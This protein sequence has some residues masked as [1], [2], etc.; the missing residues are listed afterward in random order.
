MYCCDES[1]LKD[2][3][4]EKSI[5]I[6]FETESENDE[7]KQTTEK[8]TDF[9]Y[10]SKLWDW[11]KHNFLEWIDEWILWKDMDKPLGSKIWK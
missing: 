11:S 7:T 9:T 8:G 4:I 1:F 3:Q 5:V 6:D 10:L 2:F